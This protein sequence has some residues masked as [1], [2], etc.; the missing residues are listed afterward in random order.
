LRVSTTAIV[1]SNRGAIGFGGFLLG[2]GVGYLIL[3]EISLTTNSVAWVLIIIGGALVASTLI[4]WMSPGL[5]LHRIVGGMAGGL[6]VALILTQG[7]NFFTGIGNFNL[8]YSTTEH[9]TYTGAAPQNS[10]YLRVGSMNGQITLTTWNKNEYSIEA[11]ITARGTSQ[12]EADDNLAKLGK[13]LV[14]ESTISLQRLTLVY[15]SPIMINNPYQISLEVKMPANAKLDLDLT[16]SNGAVTIS[17]VD[18]G[19]V[20]VH[21]S[22]GALRLINVKADT[23]RGSTSNGP[24]TGN[25]DSVTCTLSTSNGPITIQIPSTRSGAYTLSTSNGNAEVTVSAAGE[26]RLDGTTS[27]ADVTFSIPNL[28]YSRNTKTS[29]AAQTTGYDSAQ[30]KISVNIQTSNGAI[31]VRRNVS[32]I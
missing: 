4:R 32:S 27:N 7:F 21:T 23:L 25:V 6:V 5:E 20:V 19:N 24:V 30:T 1:M 2:L 12:K 13:E 28:T 18:S 14:K 9:K 16:T 31:T 29:K 8:P 22:N 11:T 26:Y 17:N 15:D 3:R 10:I